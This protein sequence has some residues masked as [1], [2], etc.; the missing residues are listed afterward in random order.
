MQSHKYIFA[1]N[2]KATSNDGKINAI[3]GKILV[4]ELW[5]KMFSTNQIAEFF[6]M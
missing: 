2:L 4:L 6:K 3:F 1:R 5:V